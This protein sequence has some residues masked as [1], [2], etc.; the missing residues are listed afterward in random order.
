M[1]VFTGSG[2]GVNLIG[3]NSSPEN[4]EITIDL[5][6][7]DVNESEYTSSSTNSPR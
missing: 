7:E 5:I 1:E 4:T 3:I 2:I 6:E